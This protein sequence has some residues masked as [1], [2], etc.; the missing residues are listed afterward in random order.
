M[1][2]SKFSGL[3]GG[4]LR[5]GSE[6]TIPTFHKGGLVTQPVTPISFVDYQKAA[7]A[8]AMTLRG[9]DGLWPYQREALEMLN[10][11]NPTFRVSMRQRKIS[12]DTRTMLDDLDRVW[13][14][15]NPG[16]TPTVTITVTVIDTATPELERAS[17]LI[18][19]KIAKGNM[20][21]R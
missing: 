19:E 8:Q 4:L 9:K 15:M 11:R 10:R 3:F 1:K 2:E 14:L 18:R 13:K 5:T 16:M 6:A 21:V 20:R 7:D 12:A 17:A